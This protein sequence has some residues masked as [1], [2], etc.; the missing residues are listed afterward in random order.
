M[1]EIWG[2]VDSKKIYIIGFFLQIIR[3]KIVNKGVMG[4]N[5]YWKMNIF[6][7]YECINMN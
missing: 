1:N 7:I 3:K 5:K 2:F 4:M 6:K